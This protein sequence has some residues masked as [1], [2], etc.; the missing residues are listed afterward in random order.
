M[1]VNLDH[2]ASDVHCEFDYWPLAVNMPPTKV[3]PQCK[4]AVT[5]RWKTCERCD[6]VFRSKRKA[7]CKLRE[8]AIKSARKAKDKLHKACERVS[9]IRERTLHTPV[10]RNKTECAW[11]A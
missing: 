1:R 3:C 11:Q 10:G 8:K 2:V 7:E 6:H 5:V 4:A 9:E